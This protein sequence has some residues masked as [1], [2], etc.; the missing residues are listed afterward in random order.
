MGDLES[1]TANAAGNATLE[2]QTSRITLSPGPL[3]LFDSN[4]SAIIVH[5][6]PDQG[7]TGAPGSGVAGGPRIACGVISPSF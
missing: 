6:N 7:I 5:Q 2:Y 1:L 3:S 4:G